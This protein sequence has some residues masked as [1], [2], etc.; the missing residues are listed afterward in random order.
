MHAQHTLGGQGTA[1]R[2][3]PHSPGGLWGGFFYCL[4]LNCI[5][6]APWSFSCWELSLLCLPPG[7][8]E[9]QSHQKGFQGNQREHLVEMGYEFICI[10]I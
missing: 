9:G 2:G 8:S 6:R 1:L 7:R 3:S 10:F 5:P 4:L